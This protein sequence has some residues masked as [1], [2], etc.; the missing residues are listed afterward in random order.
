MWAIIEA[1]RGVLCDAGKSGLARVVMHNFPRLGQ[2]NAVP[3]LL[4]AEWVARVFQ[5]NARTQAA[6][7]VM[8]LGF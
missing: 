7:A 8:G 5:N 3:L 4:L 6:A 1:L 2:G